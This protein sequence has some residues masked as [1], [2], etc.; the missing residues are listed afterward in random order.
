MASSV[1]ILYSDIPGKL[2]GLNSNVEFSSTGV[3]PLRNVRGGARRTFAASDIASS[4]T[5]WTEFDLGSGVS[6]SADYFALL[7]TKDLQDNTSAES[8]SV[9]PS[10]T[11]FQYPTSLSSCVAFWE[12]DKGITSNSSNQVSAWID[13]KSGIQAYQGTA[14]QQPIISRAD[15]KENIHPYSSK[16][17]QGLP[18]AIRSTI[19]ANTSDT[20]DPLGGNLADK[21]TEDSS[22]SNTHAVYWMNPANWTIAGQQYRIS[23]YVKRI[24]GDRNVAVTFANNLGAG[25]FTWNAGTGAV[26]SQSNGTASAGVDVGN[27]WWRVSATVTAGSGGTYAYLYLTDSSGNL[28]Y[29][30]DG[31]SAI[32]TFGAQVQRASADTDYVATD[33]N[34]EIAGVN[35]QRALWLN[36]LSASGMSLAIDSSYTDLNLTGEFTIIA[37]VRTIAT[38]AYGS[39]LYIFFGGGS[40]VPQNG[41]FFYVNN[42][43]FQPNAATA[44]TGVFDYIGSS[45]A[46]STNASEVIGLVRR[47][48]TSNT[49][50]NSSSIGSTVLN[51]AGSYTG[52]RY[53]GAA[54]GGTAWAW[55]GYIM[56]LAIYNT[57]LTDEQREGVENYFYDKY[58]APPL[59]HSHDY[60]QSLVGTASDDYIA[61][62]STSSARRFWQVGLHMNRQTADS[63]YLGKMMLGS[64]LDLGYDP[65]YETGYVSLSGDTYFDSGSVDFSTT[66]TRR[67]AVTLKYE[68]VTDAL[69]KTFQDK[70]AKYWQTRRIALYA[71][72]NSKV[73]AGHAMVYGRIT[74][75]PTITKEYNDWNTIEF[76]FEEEI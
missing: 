46:I 34:Y 5:I 45:S 3:Y 7:N 2:A 75:P 10:R 16:L 24:S 60:T 61:T 9:F 31:T 62:N 18:G 54:S 37:A 39:T 74:R 58:K 17:S 71:P 42:T 29:S 52:T 30:G 22:A 68:A 4:S 1:K 40:S 14:S 25:Y 53:I 47:S 20:L 26:I 13:Q 56:G 28:T 12:A 66:K 55:P 41:Y 32:Y 76:D 19:S 65:I 50:L 49:Y 72:T 6:Q 70:I 57:A 67:L 69:V 33:G 35:G 73:L 38:A 43:T 48:G 8:I 51:A 36:G 59:V 15:N 44:D 63:V 27:G 23:F 64:Q 21:I 11:S